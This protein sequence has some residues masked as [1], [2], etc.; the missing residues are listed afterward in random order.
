MYF[1]QASILFSTEKA[2]Y[3]PILVSFWPILAIL[4]RIYAL[5][6]VLFTGL[7]KAVVYQTW[8]R[9]G[10]R[11]WKRSHGKKG[12]NGSHFSGNDGSLLVEGKMDDRRLRDGDVKRSANQTPTILPPVRP[13][14]Q[15]NVFSGKFLRERKYSSTNRII[16]FLQ[17]FLLHGLH[18]PFAKKYQQFWSLYKKNS[19]LQLQK[20]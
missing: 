9:W 7:N 12:P 6:G 8:Q 1:F 15:E 3:W 16:G 19:R 14:S 11:H 17:G 5:F 4:S 13:C 2:H 18:F 20:E 10:N